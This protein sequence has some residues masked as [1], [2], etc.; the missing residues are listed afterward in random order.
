MAA[1]GAY[2]DDVVA[3]LRDFFAPAAH[4]Q[5]RLWNVGL[6]LELMETLEASEAV[7]LRVLSQEA[8]GWFADR[9]RRRVALDPG[10]GDLLQ[11]TALMEL[12]KRDL[13]ADGLNYLM[14]KQFV[15]DIQG[16]YLSR[17]AGE[18]RQSP[19]PPGRERTA[20]AL[21]A[22]LLDSGFGLANLTAWLDAMVAT[23]GPALDVADLFDDS[24]RLVGTALVTYEVLV[25]F[26]VEPSKKATRPTEWVTSAAAAAWLRTQGFVVPGLRQRGGLLL[27]VQARDEEGAVSAVAD[28][29]DRFIARVVV[30][31]PAAFSVHP[32][33]FLKGGR[34]ANRT[35][36]RRQ[37]KVH[38]LTRAD[39]VYDLQ[40]VGPIDSALELLS[41]L[42]TAAPPVAVAA[43]WSAI[44]SLLVGPGDKANVAA[45]DR[46]AAL[47]ACSWPRAEFTDLAWAKAAQGDEPLCNELFKLKTN[48]EK[49]QRIADELVPGKGVA[50]TDASDIAAA[51]RMAKL[52]GNPGTVLR[53]VRLHAT[54]CFRRLYRVRN[55]ILHGG[56]ISPVALEATLR[57]APPLVG[58]GMDR[59]THAY[60]V[61]N[62]LPLELAARAEIEL[63]RAGSSAAPALTDLLE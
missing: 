19:S 42:D 30:G 2:A 12:L 14:L 27:S 51:R 15:D 62:R 32:Q 38:A 33:I 26:E 17:W 53:D 63:A 7:R 10:A 58:A 48:R 54:E 61:S 35:R 3:R 59:I 60:L 8:L 47:V 57:T 44:E 16:S 50:L 52:L 24:V 5:R 55:V 39:R 34:T 20:R 13:A 41:H 18:L 25:L 40:R 21:A 56:R 22:H 46:L 23:A 28:T 45:A 36:P 31:T 11:R 6:L 49:A 37:V 29:V 43:G 1:T 9:V 4:W